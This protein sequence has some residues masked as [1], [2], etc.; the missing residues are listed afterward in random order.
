MTKVLMK[1]NLTEVIYIIT[2]YSC[3]HYR[4]QE[5]DHKGNVYSGMRV[6]KEWLKKCQFLNPEN[7]VYAEQFC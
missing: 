6:T 1:D 7:V 3:G 2:R 4:W 5:V